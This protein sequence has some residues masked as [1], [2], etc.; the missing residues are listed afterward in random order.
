MTAEIISVGT[1]ILMGNIVNTNAAFIA[2]R[3]SALGISC[4]YQTV[5]GDNADRLKDQL[6][7]S[8]KRSDIVILSGGLGPTEDDLTKETAASVCGYKLVEDA[9]ARQDIAEYFKTRGKEPTENNWKQAMV[10]EGCTVLYNPNGTAPGIIMQKGDQHVVLLPGPPDELVPMFKK[11]VEKYLSSLSEDVIV[12]RTIKLCGVGE[13]SAEEAILDLIDN[14][15]N[16]TIATYAKIREVHIRVTA[17]AKNIKEAK[18]ILQ[19]TVREIKKRFKDNIFATEEEVTL[20]ASVIDLL[21]KK[22]FSLSIAESCTGGLLSA[23]LINVPGAS[24]VYK[25]G[26]VVYSNKAKR[27]LLGLKKKAIDKYGAVSAQTAEEMTKGLAMETKSDVCVSITGIAGPGGGSAEKP[28]GLVYIA[29]NVKGKITVR[30]YMFKGT[31]AKIR[32]S[33]AAEALILIRECVAN[34]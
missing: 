11:Q 6:K 24:E 17:R 26:F 7:R 21:K 13:S 8:L 27:K 22:N 28:V 9:K 33:S 25:S 15:T 10:P 32:E 18:T 34:R 23:R 29:C 3:L 20:E 1:E 19:P 14:Q 5:V 4:Y 30:Q 31:R 16:P 2:E 12:S